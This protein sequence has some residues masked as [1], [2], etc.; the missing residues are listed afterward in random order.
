MEVMIRHS[1]YQRSWY[2]VLSRAYTEFPKCLVVLV[3]RKRV[4]QI[5][6]GTRSHPQCTAPITPSQLSPSYP[7]NNVK[8]RRPCFRAM[9]MLQRCPVPL[10]NTPEP[11]KW[12]GKHACQPCKSECAQESLTLVQE[13]FANRRTAEAR[14][15]ISRADLALELVVIRKFVV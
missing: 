8:A 5:L 7:N 14:N 15:A 3:A 12:K 11:C 9:E 4:T 13:A 2:G 1:G 6:G 10:L